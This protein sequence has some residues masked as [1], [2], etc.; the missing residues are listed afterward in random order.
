[1]IEEV[2]TTWKLPI[3]H[4]KLPTLCII[5]WSPRKL[6]SASFRVSSARGREGLK[7]VRHMTII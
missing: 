6:S 3:M 2:Q 4:R 7:K 5:M 1:M